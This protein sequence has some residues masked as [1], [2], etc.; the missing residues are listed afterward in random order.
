MN[1]PRLHSQRN[2]GCIKSEG[3]VGYAIT[4]SIPNGWRKRGGHKKT[5]ACTSNKAIKSLLWY[6]DIKEK[7]IRLQTFPV[8][9]LS[10]V[11]TIK[12]VFWRTSRILLA[13]VPST[14]RISGLTKVDMQVSTFSRYTPKASTVCMTHCNF[15]LNFPL[16]S[17][18][19]F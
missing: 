14:Y 6:T 8:A 12:Q 9:N 1:I 5:P 17:Y 16:P 18:A 13:A 11:F 3:T 7:E 4:L 15:C 10:L 19:W 2:S